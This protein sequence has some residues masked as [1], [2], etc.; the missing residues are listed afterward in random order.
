MKKPFTLIFLLFCGLSVA[1]AQ[2]GKKKAT[3][4]SAP[5]TVTAGVPS[6]PTENAA[7]KTV[8]IQ[9]RMIL[10]DYIKMMS[11]DLEYMK[12]V[13]FLS[14]GFALDYNPVSEKTDEIIKMVSSANDQ[15]KVSD[16]IMNLLPKPVYFEGDFSKTASQ[17]H[18]TLQLFFADHPSILMQLGENFSKAFEDEKAFQEYVF[19]AY[20][21]GYYTKF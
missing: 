8:K 10:R 11:G 21:A 12:N 9:P 17:Y 20:Q 5:K 16:L 2:T 3:A 4:P 14:D 18:S 6:K 7:E 19:I 13:V 1:T 15:R